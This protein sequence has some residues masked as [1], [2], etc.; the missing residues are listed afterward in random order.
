MVE[1]IRRGDELAEEEDEEEEEVMEEDEDGLVA[2]LTAPLVRLDGSCSDDSGSS[3]T[4]LEEYNATSADLFSIVKGA[5]GTGTGRDIFIF[6]H[7]S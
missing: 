4:A 3:S 5:L 7:G 1:G 2:V 6:L